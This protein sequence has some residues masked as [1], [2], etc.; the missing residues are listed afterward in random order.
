MRVYQFR[1]PSPVGKIVGGGNM[2]EPARWQANL[3]KNLEF[4][5]LEHQGLPVGA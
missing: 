4:S 3:L 2:E 5:P 1:H